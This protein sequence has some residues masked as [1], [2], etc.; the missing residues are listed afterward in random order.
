MK[1]ACEQVSEIL[2]K[3]SG[4]YMLIFGRSNTQSYF[5]TLQLMQKP[6]YCT[7]FICVRGLLLL[8]YSIRLSDYFTH[9]GKGR[10]QR[11]TR[12]TRGTGTGGKTGVRRPHQNNHK[13]PK[14]IKCFTAKG[15][16][17]LSE[18]CFMSPNEIHANI[19][20]MLFQGDEGPIGPPGQTGLEVSYKINI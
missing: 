6:K 11:F 5:A 14:G 20:I 3:C 17:F 2:L 10:S 1:G 13:F 19:N 15:L 12:T 8:Q 16:S 18:G 9:P 7:D 4:A